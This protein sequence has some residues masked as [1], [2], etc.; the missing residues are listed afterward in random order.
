MR[1]WKTRRGGAS[2]ALVAAGSIAVAA[3]ACADRPF[4]GFHVETDGD[5]D[6]DTI[7]DGDGDGDTIGD[8]DGDGDTIGDGDGDGDS[9]T[10]G[11]GDGDGDPPP[12]PP[13]CEAI[14]IGAE[15]PLEIVGST[16]GEGDDHS[17]GCLPDF[18][19]SDVFFRWRAPVDA[20]YRFELFGHGYD[21][22]LAILGA[23]CELPELACNDDNQSLDSMVLLDLDEGE[24]ITIVADGFGGDAGEFSLRITT[25][26]C[27]EAVPLPSQTA[28]S[29]GGQ[30]PAGPSN[31][32]GTCA[33]AGPERVFEFVPPQTGTYA[34][35]TTGSAFDTVLYARNGACGGDELACN[36]DFDDSL[37]SHVT[38]DLTADVPIWIVLDAYSEFD[39]GT[40]ELHLALQ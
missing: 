35:H 33:G 37:Q 19:S 24:E 5:G 2:R 21:P 28:I 20:P 36:D 17:L 40:F 11:D 10:V 8:G 27:D 6:G 13:E 4:E 39:Y 16:V 1:E 7:G 3:A 9:D 23:E 14:D 30:L 12:P 38:L 25:A 15:V 31:T 32:S 26:Q 34:V 22:A 18:D 29:I